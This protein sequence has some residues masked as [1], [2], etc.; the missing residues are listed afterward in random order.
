MKCANCGHEVEE[1][2]RYCPICGN[3]ILNTDDTGWEQVVVP[4][5]EDKAVVPDAEPNPEVVE[6]NP[7]VVEPKPEV[8]P[9]LSDI[10]PEEKTN[11]KQKPAKKKDFPFVLA[12]IALF[13]LLYV[14]GALKTNFW[15]YYYRFTNPV[16]SESNKDP[17]EL[18]VVEYEGILYNNLGSVNK[19]FK[20]NLSDSA[21]SSYYN[22]GV[23]VDKDYDIYLV[24]GYDLTTEY[25]DHVQ[26][27]A[28]NPNGRFLYYIDDDSKLKYYD[29]G[30]KKLSV[31]KSAGKVISAEMSVIGDYLCVEEELFVDFKTVYIVTVTDLDGNKVQEYKYPDGELHLLYSL[32]N[33]G[34]TV[35]LTSYMKDGVYCE[36]D[37]YCL[38]DGEMKEVYTENLDYTSCLNINMDKMLIQDEHGIYLY[39][40]ED[41]EKREICKD[42][43]YNIC[44]KENVAFGDGY[45]I[46]E[47]NFEGTVIYDDKN[48]YWLSEDMKLVPFAQNGDIIEETSDVVGSGDGFRFIYS[49][50][51]GVHLATYK[52]G[53]ADDMTLLEGPV[54]VCEIV[55]DGT[56][57]HA[58][59]STWNQE[60][61]HI[62]GRYCDRIYKGSDKESFVEADYD[63]YSEYVYFIMAGHKLIGIDKDEEMRMKTR[64][65]KCFDS[66]FKNTGSIVFE[67]LNDNKHII[68]FDKIKNFSEE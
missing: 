19:E 49:C 4:D 40:A 43:E 10:I 21:Y 55:T 35:F 58:W 16:V 57:E 53:A 41:G 31:Y 33:D 17:N 2:A 38:H 7:E 62:Y 56:L 12:G 47:D 1:G 50:K 65:V 32:S 36:G 42:S 15:N 34:K 30:T 27:Y 11:T 23:V 68:I 25:L 63:R 44:L 66:S 67:D 24:Q 60:I 5:T 13:I 29:F 59:L 3:P 14:F 54:R 6:P 45:V 28:L 48:Y 20:G 37:M 18:T 64:G 8:K 46:Q 61:Y 26:A 52:D 22:T 39:T 51:D 9:V